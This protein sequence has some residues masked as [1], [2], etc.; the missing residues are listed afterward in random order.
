MSCTDRTADF[1][2]VVRALRESDVA[3]EQTGEK[4]SNGIFACSDIFRE[5]FKRNV[6]R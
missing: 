5:K 1:I 6:G 3:L 2:S 4:V